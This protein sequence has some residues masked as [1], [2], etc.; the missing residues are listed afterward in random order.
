MLPAIL[1]LP[2]WHQ[3]ATRLTGVKRY[4]LELFK[5]SSTIGSWSYLQ[6]GWSKMGGVPLFSGS[7]W[8]SSGD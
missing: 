3:P 2:L 5:T 7:M 1:L 4:G 8:R 6:A